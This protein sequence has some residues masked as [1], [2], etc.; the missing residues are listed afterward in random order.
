MVASN[1]SLLVTFSESFQSFSLWFPGFSADLL[2]Y[3]NGK[4]PE[5]FRQGALVS[6]TVWTDR[7][8]GMLW[9]MQVQ[10]DLYSHFKKHN[11]TKCTNFSKQSWIQSKSVCLLI[12]FFTLFQSLFCIEQK[13]QS[14]L[15]ILY[16]ICIFLLFVTGYW[17]LGQHMPFHYVQFRFILFYLF[18]LYISF[19]LSI[20]LSTSLYRP[21]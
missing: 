8:K 3:T 1:Q 20:C 17:F 21:P 6:L 5:I 2:S 12:L 7:I 15:N 4:Q 14:G 11:F 18:L 16:N 19:S 10:S 9:K 13:Q